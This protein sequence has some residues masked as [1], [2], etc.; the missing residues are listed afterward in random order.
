MKL[1]IGK[2]WV[3][4]TQQKASYMKNVNKIDK[5]IVRLTKIKSENTDHN[6]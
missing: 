1:K 3:K 2:Q 6:Y 4:S 5:P